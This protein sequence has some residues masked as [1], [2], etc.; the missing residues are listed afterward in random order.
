MCT[1][2]EIKS[3]LKLVRIE[4]DACKFLL[5]INLNIG[6]SILLFC[7]FMLNEDLSQNVGVFH[8][9]IVLD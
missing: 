3:G 1:G 6:I 5:R 9:E 2:K 4:T 8:L 7:K